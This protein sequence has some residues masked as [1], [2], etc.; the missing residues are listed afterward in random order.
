LYAKFEKANKISITIISIGN[1]GPHQT[2]LIYVSIYEDNSSFPN[3]D[4]I[5]LGYLKQLEYYTI[6]NEPR[7]RYKTHFVL[8]TNLATLVTEAYAGKNNHYKRV[9]VVCHQ[10]ISSKQNMYKHY[11]RYHSGEVKKPKI[12][13]PKPPNNI[14]C[15]DIYN[16]KHFKKTHRYP[17]VVYADFESFNLKHDKD[18][19][20][21]VSSK[22][23]TLPQIF[24][25]YPLSPNHSQVNQ[26]LPSNIIP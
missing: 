5:T 1:E 14:N 12:V 20:H 17:F 10:T 3:A 19:T 26:I 22:L 13:L 21:G 2:N 25:H 8:V 16:E 4:R 6:N 11:I 23:R 7:V 15:F 24:I 9:C 18:A